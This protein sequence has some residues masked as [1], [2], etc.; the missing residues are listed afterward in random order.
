MHLG[1]SDPPEVSTESVT[2][3]FHV[4]AV[5]DA[6]AADVAGVNEGVQ[7]VRRHGEVSLEIKC[8]FIKPFTGRVAFF[9]HGF[10]KVVSLLAILAD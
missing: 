3:V 6:P 4:R 5:E 8:E 7:L 10:K 9:W 2:E 1:Q